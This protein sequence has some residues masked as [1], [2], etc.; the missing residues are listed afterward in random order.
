MNDLKIENKPTLNNTSH[1]D[2]D[3]QHNNGHDDHGLQAEFT[4]L[5]IYSIGCIGHGYFKSIRLCELRFITT[6]FT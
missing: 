4:Q 3:H 6:C 5:S 2:H 1:V